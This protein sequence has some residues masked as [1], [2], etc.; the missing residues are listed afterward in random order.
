MFAPAALSHSARS[1]PRWRC[2]H[3]DYSPVSERIKN[4]ATDDWNDQVAV[5]R[6]ESRGGTFLRGEARF[7]GAREVEVDGKRHRARRA[8]VIAAGGVP[9]SPDPRSG[10]GRVLDQPRSGQGDSAAGV[11]DRARRRRDRS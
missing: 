5:D 3:A 6:L 11:D 2:S 4:E 8:V 1:D 10:L 7:V 9:P